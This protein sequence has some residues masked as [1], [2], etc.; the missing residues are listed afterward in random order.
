MTNIDEAILVPTNFFRTPQDVIRA[1]DL[2]RDQKIKILRSWEYDARELE[3]AEEENM[4]TIEPD[5]LD[6][7][8]TALNALEAG[9]EPVFSSPNK[10]GGKWS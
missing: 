2:T 7:I 9:S 1:E 8:L 10:Q 6:Q 3:V 5:I 4:R